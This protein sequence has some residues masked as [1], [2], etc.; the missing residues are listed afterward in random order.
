MELLVPGAKVLESK[1]SSYL[2]VENIP[3]HNIWTAF[4]GYQSITFISGSAAH[5]NL[6]RETRARELFLRFRDQLLYFSFLVLFEK[7]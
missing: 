4:T 2:L 6:K 7:S 3:R 1:I 5:R